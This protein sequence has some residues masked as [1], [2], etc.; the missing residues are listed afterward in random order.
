M[1]TCLPTCHL[2]TCLPAYLPTCLL[3]YLPTCLPAYRL[4]YLPTC[5]PAYLPTCLPAYMSTCLP[6]N[7]PTCLPATLMKIHI[8]RGRGV[9]AG[10]YT[11]ELV[12]QLNVYIKIANF[13]KQL[14]IH[15]HLHTNTFI[16]IF[17][18]ITRTIVKPVFNTQ[19]LLSETNTHRN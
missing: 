8:N 11:N 16:K 9:R 14:T 19:L 2:P 5:L 13:Y 7:R 10:G 17:V 12:V 1:P 6:V 18:D 3:A 4:A 15:M